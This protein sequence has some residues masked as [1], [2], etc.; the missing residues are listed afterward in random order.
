MGSARTTDEHRTEAIAALDQI[1][2]GNQRFVDGAPESHIV[3]AEDRA[4]FVDKQEPIAALLGCVDARVPPEIITDL[5]AGDLLTVRT[6]G[7]ALTGV[8]LGSLEFAVRVLGLPL[9]VV[10]GHTGCGAV[11]AALADDR[12]DGHLGDLAGEVASRL[13]AVVGDDP[14]RATGANLEATVDAL[15]EL[16]TLVSPD[17]HPTY[18]VGALYDMATGVIEITDDAGLGS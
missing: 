14:V 11:L 12:P 17:G 4:R 13:E 7:Q 6:A 1:L 16:G 5:G 10:L 3:T 2:A 8:T 18:V 9:L 15:R